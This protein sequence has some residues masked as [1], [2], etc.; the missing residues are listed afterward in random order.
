M[1]HNNITFCGQ[2][3]DFLRYTT[4]LAAAEAR[5]GLNDQHRVSLE[6][7]KFVPQTYLSVSQNCDARQSVKA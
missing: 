1:T 3:K 4:V 5:R 7:Y 2:V 6:P